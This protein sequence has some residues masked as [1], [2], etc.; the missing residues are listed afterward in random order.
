MST[1]IVHIGDFH[2]RP[3]AR[4]PERYR[5][6]DQV[7]T[8]AEALPRLGLW[9]WPGDLNHARMTI[10]DKNAL[11]ARVQRM[12]QRA[13]VLVCRGNHDEPGDLDF[14]A[15]IKAGFPIDVV[16]EPGCVRVRMATGQFA[17]VFV[18]PYPDKARLVAAG[19]AK[20]DV[21][22]VGADLFEPIFMAAAAELEAARAAGDLT[23]MIGHINVAGSR[24]SVG[25]PN[26]GRELEL[27][28]KHLDRLGD[29][30]KLLNHIHYGQE[31]AGAWYAGSVTR[32]NFGEV[33]P[34]RYLVVHFYD[35]DT[36]IVSCPIDVP[37]MWHIEGEL[38]RDGFTWQAK[39]GERGAVLEPPASWKGCEVRVRYR[40][41]A[42]EKSILAEA[43]VLA[44]FADALRLKVEPVA[45]PDRDPRAPEVVAA[46]TLPAKVAACLK[47]DLLELS[48]EQKVLA[49]EHAEP[50]QL[51]AEVDRLIGRLEA[52]AEPAVAA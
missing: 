34:K 49:L 8:E 46:R 32:Q 25:Q 47:T 1:S 41:K 15:H 37:A 33:E 30:P 48:L 26:I 40:Y 23:L 24:T 35:E 17:T 31:I 11:R 29:I 5:A 39:A 52:E 9:V 38:T 44:E 20:T 28:P 6:L 7:I 51:L 18:L 42:S 50:A 21:I 4:N 27:S 45:V 13:P 36:Q 14:L 43:R 2:A 16:N 22:G 12:G 10:A 3:D 19:V